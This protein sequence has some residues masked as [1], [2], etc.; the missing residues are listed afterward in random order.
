MNYTKMV[1]DYLI[2]NSIITNIIESENLKPGEKCQDKLFQVDE[3]ITLQI[4]IQYENLGDVLVK[5][6][7]ENTGKVLCSLEGSMFSSKVDA[8]LNNKTD[9]DYK[10]IS[11]EFNLP[12]FTIYISTEESREADDKIVYEK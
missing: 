6:F 9:I 4:T 5:L 7:K 11:I 2:F 8:N 10:Y 3:N 1:F 12:C